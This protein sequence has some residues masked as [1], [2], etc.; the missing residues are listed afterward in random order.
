MLGP[1]ED[2][3]ADGDKLPPSHRA[4]LQVVHRNGLRLQRLV[5]RLLEFSLI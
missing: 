3:L 4:Q 2:A 5:N 1:V